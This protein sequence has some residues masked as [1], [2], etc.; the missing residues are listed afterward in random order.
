MRFCIVGAALQRLAKSIF[1]FAVS[2]LANQKNAVI[3]VALRKVR[4]DSDGGPIL[5]LSFVGAASAGIKRD[6]VRVRLRE[7]RVL[8]HSLLML[9]DGAIQ[10]PCVLKIDSFHQMCQG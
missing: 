3:V 6:Q 5:C 8:L 9:S 1:S 4:V 7:F 10:L 2:L